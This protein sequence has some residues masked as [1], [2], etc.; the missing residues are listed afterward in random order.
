MNFT[1]PIRLSERYFF[2]SYFTGLAYADVKKLTKRNILI[3]IDSNKW[4]NIKRTNTNTLS[5]I[6]ILPA[7]ANVIEKYTNYPD[8][9]HSEKLLSLLS[10][11]KMNA[12]L[13]EIAD[14]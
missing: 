12:Y 13:K 8:V 1:F 6:P 2:L 3:G 10:N 9:L 5:N 7:V 11:Q 14:L 4:I